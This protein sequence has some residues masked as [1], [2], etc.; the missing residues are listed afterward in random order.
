MLQLSIE[1]NRSSHPR[2][3]R[4]KH[5]S[6]LETA[7][8]EEQKPSSTFI[9]SVPATFR[10]EDQPLASQAAVDPEADQEL[11]TPNDGREPAA[12]VRTEILECEIWNAIAEDF[13]RAFDESADYDDEEFADK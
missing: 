11:D 8:G 6:L 12:W 1:S 4:R 5:I 9:P 13:S 3:W 7:R 10:C 2:A